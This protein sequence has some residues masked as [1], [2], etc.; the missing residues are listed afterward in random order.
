MHALVLDAPHLVSA[1]ANP[2]SD[3]ARLLALCAYGALARE[4][5]GQAGYANNRS[6][7]AA[8]LSR[9]RGVLPPGTPDDLLLVTSLEVL[10]DVATLTREVQRRQRNVHPHMVRNRILAHSWD[11][12]TDLGERS[13]YRP[14][15]AGRREHVV[16]TAIAARAQSIVT[17]D[18]GLLLRG[19][20]VYRDEPTGHEVRP[21]RL[22]AFVGHVLPAGLRFRAFDPVE[23]LRFAT[24]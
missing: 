6:R 20:G 11:V 10:D 14:P 7:A 21:R 15:A 24:D 8:R 5:A 19:D 4:A 3:S 16:R 22:A 18:R 13:V 9:V 2:R 12:L 17:E 1:L 23:V